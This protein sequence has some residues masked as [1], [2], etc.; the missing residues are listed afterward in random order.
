MLFEKKFNVQK[1]KMTD[2]MRTSIL[3]EVRK[4]IEV[5]KS[6]AESSSSE[7]FFTQF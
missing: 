1:F 2:E 5:N 6:D 7:H 4:V 3:D